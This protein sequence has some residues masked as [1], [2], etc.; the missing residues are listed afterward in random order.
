MVG[1]KLVLDSWEYS[2]CLEL[3]EA[4][5]AEPWDKCTQDVQARDPFR[6]LNVL[7]RVVRKYLEGSRAQ[8]SRAHREK[9]GFLS[10]HT[11]SK[12]RDFACRMILGFLYYNGC[13]VN[14]AFILSIMKGGANHDRVISKEEYEGFIYREDFWTTSDEL[15]RCNEFSNYDLSGFLCGT[16]GLKEE[17]LK[18]SSWDKISEFVGVNVCVPGDTFMSEYFSRNMGDEGDE[19]DEAGESNEDDEDNE[20]DK[21]NEDNESDNSDDVV[22]VDANIKGSHKRVIGDVS[23]ANIVPG[24]RKRFKTDRLGASTNVSSR[25][26]NRIH[27]RSN[28]TD[29]GNEHSSDND[30][31]VDQKHIDESGYNNDDNG[32]DDDTPGNVS[33]DDSSGA[34]DNTTNGDNGIVTDSTTTSDN[35]SATS[36]VTNG[37]D[38]SGATDN[39]T[40]GDNGIVTDSATTSDN[41]SATSSVTNVDVGDNGSATGSATVGN[42][43]DVPSSVNIGDRGSIADNV[44]EGKYRSDMIKFA[45]TTFNRR[46]EQLHLQQLTIYSELNRLADMCDVLEDETKTI[47]EVGS[48]LESYHDRTNLFISDLV[49]GTTIEQIVELKKTIITKMVP[50]MANVLDTIL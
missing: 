16:E 13:K 44:S 26:G 25:N 37:D 50:R 3:I 11:W 2:C 27:T 21:G 34:T 35:G 5:G 22:I 7:L 49:N 47:D 18:N 42:N 17:E 43:G 38:S 24:S 15:K 33:I 32:D 8:T 39:T 6:N 40:N 9:R 30:S 4:A 45:T 20:S 31:D 28:V 23:P 29:N 46:L 19:G 1:N 36:S 41:G 48:A 10:H 12:I 14:P